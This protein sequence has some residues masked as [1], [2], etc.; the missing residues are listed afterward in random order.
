MELG[1]DINAIDNNGKT[2]LQYAP[3][4]SE[5]NQIIQMLTIDQ[6]NKS[7]NRF[8]ESKD[9]DQKII[10]DKIPDIVEW[11]QKYEQDRYKQE[12]EETLKF[13][14]LKKR[15]IDTQDPTNK[16][17]LEIESQIAKVS[18]KSQL[19][20]NELTQTFLDT[21]GICNGLSLRVIEAAVTHNLGGFIK[22]MNYV[23]HTAPP[24][25]DA[26]PEVKK[27]F[28][29]NMNHFI[30]QTTQM[31]P[32][33]GRDV[34]GLSYITNAHIL[35]EASDE[36]IKVRDSYFVTDNSQLLKWAKNSEVGTTLL[37][38]SAYHQM[39]MYI[40]QDDHGK[41]IVGF[42]DPNNNNLIEYYQD[43]LKRVPVEFDPLCDLYNNGPDKPVPPVLICTEVISNSLEKRVKKC[44]DILDQLSA[45]PDYSIAIQN[46]K[47]DGVKLSQNRDEL[48]Q[49]LKT[50]L[51]AKDSPTHDVVE[52]FM[53]TI[54][55]D[56]SDAGRD[57]KYSPIE[58]YKNYDQ[59]ISK[60]YGTSHLD[61]N[62]RTHILDHIGGYH[63][64]S[65]LQRIQKEQALNLPEVIKLFLRSLEYHNQPILEKIFS[66]KLITKESY[67]EIAAAP[68]I[69]ELLN[70]EITLGHTDIVKMLVQYDNKAGAI[71]LSEA[72]DLLHNSNY[73]FPNCKFQLLG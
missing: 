68:K 13:L 23:M 14:E 60:E 38:S 61:Q 31:Q 71:F 2:P 55:D 22:K 64:T 51:S 12:R 58:M 50:N 72:L 65:A 32:R 45:D 9:L 39:A 48:K 70:E 46:I 37:I 41:K 40:D 42:Y 62:Q 1:A 53:K 25:D 4:T 11:M 59:N 54:T 8:P 29:N 35:N 16:E 26:A 15:T 17:L 43:G 34:G 7:I 33:H 44:V 47:L 57:S 5:K 28:Y 69:L 67:A 24:L 6:T 19:D 66:Q 27:E 30:L 73:L 20:T 18:G 56:L 21:E 49:A 63:D 10:L 3:N 36:G 52:S